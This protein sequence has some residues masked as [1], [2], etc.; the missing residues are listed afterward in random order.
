MSRWGYITADGRG[1]VAVVGDDVCSS[2]GGISRWGYITADG[3]GVVA[4]IE[5][6]LT[7]TA[8]TVS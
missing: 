2:S 6:A 3:R 8:A 1:V 5:A 4:V 7:A